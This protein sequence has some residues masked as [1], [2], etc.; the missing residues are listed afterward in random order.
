[1]LASAL[2]TAAPA[3]ATAAPAPCAAVPLAPSTAA[4]A[5]VPVRRVVR[6]KRRPDSDDNNPAQAAA[7][8]ATPPS[9]QALVC[10]GRFV[11]DFHHVLGRG[12]LAVVR[13]GKHAEGAAVAIKC[14]NAP[15]DRDATETE[16][17]EERATRTFELFEREVRMLRRLHEGAASSCPV[18]TCLDYSR[19]GTS[20]IPGATPDGSCYL[21]LELGQHTLDEF[22]EQAGGPLPVAEVRALL[23][24]VV[25]CLAFL[26]GCGVVHLDFKLSNVMRFA[27]GW[28]LIDCDA[29]LAIGA[30]VDSE[31][32]CVTSVY[33][34]PEIA[35]LHLHPGTT[36]PL[37]ASAHCWSLAMGAV[38]ML[39]GEPMLRA[40]HEADG[41]E[42]MLD[43]LGTAAHDPMVA[44]E[45]HPPERIRAT[46]P[47]LHALLS[48]LLTV[49]PTARPDAAAAL[50]DPFFADG[51][52]ELAPAPS[53]APSAAL[54]AAQPQG[55]PRRGASRKVH[56]EGT[57]RERWR[58]WRLGHGLGCVIS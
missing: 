8:A 43:W 49:D 20:D 7:S 58:A 15:G 24:R 53:A 29:L 23:R 26:E 33:C 18:V 45:L 30:V 48:R 50:C 36:A 16:D 38:S 4:P 54:G 47:A 46:S 56:P 10:D 14:Y 21:V 55:T 42:A 57:P 9:G 37:C 40:R 28:K 1:M 52:E 19:N 2:A 34:P 13:G 35:T 22:L 17:E 31:D 44:A 27:S 5:L 11:L 39:C 12:G 3:P 6:R 41:T 32:V 25:E 51:F